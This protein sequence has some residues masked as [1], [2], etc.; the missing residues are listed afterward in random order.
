MIYSYTLVLALVISLVSIVRLQ[1]WTVFFLSLLD[2]EVAYRPLSLQD[3]TIVIIT[4]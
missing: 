2:H 1:V 3:A 4:D